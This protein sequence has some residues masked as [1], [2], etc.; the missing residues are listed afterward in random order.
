MGEW[1]VYYEVTHQL[2]G[3]NEPDFSKGFIYAD[4]YCEAV[5]ILDKA[6]KIIDVKLQIVSDTILELPKNIDA[7]EIIK[8]NEY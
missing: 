6:F 2:S 5:E 3:D 4:D 7:Q 1:L 8:F